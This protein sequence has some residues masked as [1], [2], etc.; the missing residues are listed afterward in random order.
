MMDLDCN[1]KDTQSNWV[2]LLRGEPTM[3][4]DFNKTQD[5]R[6]LENIWRKGSRWWSKKPVPLPPWG[7]STLNRVQWS[8]LAYAP[9]FTNWNIY[10]NRWSSWHGSIRKSYILFRSTGNFEEK[11]KYALNSSNVICAVLKPNFETK[12]WQI[13]Q[14]LAPTGALYVVVFQYMP[15]TQTIP[16]YPPPV[17]RQVFQIFP[18]DHFYDYTINQCNSSLQIRQNCQVHQVTPHT[19]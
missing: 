4:F 8:S 1:Y 17:V 18:P 12:N 15:R 16:R 9:C 14:L 19:K 13:F 11:N 6:Q 3:N 7:S 10:D 5:R 2:W